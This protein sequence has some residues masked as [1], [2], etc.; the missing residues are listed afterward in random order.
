MRYDPDTHARRSIRLPGYDYAQPGAYFVTL[1]VHQREC[2]LGEITDGEM[3]LNEFGRVVM[4]CW[5]WLAKQY[6]HVTVDEWIVMP[7][8]FHG[9]L[10]IVDAVCR[11]GSRTA[12]TNG[13]T[14]KPLGR[15][16]GAFKTV[17]TKRINAIRDT[18]GLPVWQRNYYEHIIRNE[19]ELNHIRQYIVA[20]PR[21]W[22]FDQE[23]P[24][25]R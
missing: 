10:M 14:H 2:L 18:P 9:I 8:H 5:P 20:N 12:P 17:S 19:E 15:L 1:C 3:M 21:N 7:N 11:G 22:E 23:N 6:P 24:V 13:T 16:I 4:E 25:R